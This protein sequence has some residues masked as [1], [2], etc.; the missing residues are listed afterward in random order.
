MIDVPITESYSFDHYEITSDIIVYEEDATFDLV[1]W[2]F[3]W[4]YRDVV[5]ES[6]GTA[7]VTDAAGWS[8][9]V[10][11]VESESHKRISIMV[12]GIMRQDYR[13]PTDRAS[14][15][16][17][18]DGWTPIEQTGNVTVEITPEIIIEE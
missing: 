2:N 12:D 5:H 18:D 11:V 1:S 15:V 17:P 16:M 10:S 7:F 9:I 4:T 8:D 13:P 14:P 6:M 3:Q